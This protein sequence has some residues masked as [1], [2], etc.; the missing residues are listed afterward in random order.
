MVQS[1]CSL[2]TVVF[3][4]CCAK[5]VIGNCWWEILVNQIN[6]TSQLPHLDSQEHTQ[7]FLAFVC[8]EYLIIQLF[9]IPTTIQ[10]NWSSD[11]FVCFLNN[12]L[13]VCFYVHI[14]DE[15]TLCLVRLLTEQQIW[16]SLWKCMMA[17]IWYAVKDY[18]YSH[19]K[20]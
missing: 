13:R 18:A 4:Y 12:P 2:F 6:T 20:L 7:F 11:R 9:C 19:F 8:L 1:F 17:K 3:L 16:H 14:T 15:C 5:K 10:K